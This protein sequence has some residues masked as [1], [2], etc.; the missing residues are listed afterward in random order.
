MRHILTLVLGPLLGIFIVTLGNGFISSLTSLRLDSS[1]VSPM[2]IGLISSSYF[3]GLTLGAIFSSRLIAR[4]GHIRAYS[5][6]ASLTATTFLLQGLFFDPWAWF[7]FRLINGWAIVGIFLV[8]ESWMLLAGDK[9]MRGRLLA[10]YMIGLYGSGMIG[11]MQLGTINAWGDTAPFMVAGILS[12]LSVLPMVILPRVSP[13]VSKVQPLPPLHL[14][15]MTPTGVMG[16]FGSGITIAA[17]Y[18]LLPIYL[19]HIGM[20]VK[21]VGELMASVICGAML[22]QYPVGRWSDWQDRH[23]VLV[24]LSVACAV[25]SFLILILPN[26]QPLL[27]ILLFLLGG[28]VFG[29]YPV[30]VSHSA[31]HAEPTQLVSMIQ[32][33]LL[34][35]SLG[36]AISPV[37]ISSLMDHVGS[38]GFFWAFILVNAIMALFFLWRRKLYPGISPLTSFHPATQMSPLGAEIRVTEELEQATQ[39]RQ[40]QAPA[41]AAPEAPSTPDTPPST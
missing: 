21:Q 31:E 4:I 9:K 37:A 6:F 41:P 25:L 18:T 29:V 23:I 36:S 20:D 8:V 39:E 33:L 32:G 2:L 26:Y 40:Q 27:M 13:E 19:Q 28:G 11:Q 24:S 35:N 12:S 14:M 7:V 10:I 17:V 15:R 30:A 5:S 3:I 38:S 22:L 1:G 34:I 16:C